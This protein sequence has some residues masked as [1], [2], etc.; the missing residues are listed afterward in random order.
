MNLLAHTLAFKAGDVISVREKAK[1][2]TRI[3][4][5]LVLSAQSGTP[6]WVSI[7]AA[8]DSINWK[9]KDVKIRIDNHGVII[10]AKDK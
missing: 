2:Q 5:A 3:A 6:I 9:H 1:K 7:D 10:D 8:K 4:E